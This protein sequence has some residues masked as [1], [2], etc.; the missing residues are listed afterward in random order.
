VQGHFRPV[1]QYPDQ[2]HEHG[3]HCIQPGSSKIL[4]GCAGMAEYSLEIII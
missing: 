4:A 3:Q 1:T 2:A